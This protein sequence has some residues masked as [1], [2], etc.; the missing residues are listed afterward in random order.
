LDCRIPGYDLT[1]SWEA[2]GQVGGF[3]QGE[4]PQYGFVD[5]M[6]AAYRGD[7]GTDDFGQ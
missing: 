2:E 4:F 6:W 7:A 5:D 1:A 3:L